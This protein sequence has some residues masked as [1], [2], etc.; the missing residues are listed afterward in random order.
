[1]DSAREA[2]Y[3]LFILH[4]D[5]DR[6]WVDGYL[7][8][9]IGVDTTRLVTRQGFTLGASIPAEF[10]RVVR[11]SRYTAVV[12]SPA[13]LADRWGEFGEQLVSFTSVEEDRNRIIVMTLHPCQT[14]LHVR[15]RVGLDCTDW[16]RWDEQASKIR[17]SSNGPI[18]PLRSS[19]ARI[20]GWFR[21]VLKMPPS[22]M[23][24]TRSSMTSCARSGTTRS[25]LWSVPRD[26]ASRQ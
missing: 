14:P 1:M 3:D 5:A 8:H 20:R 23:G 21:S 7:K 15:F 26:R 9:A 11:S 25:Y 2:C 17:R 4:A 22:F 16:T 10:D 6:A 12:L 13:F 19:P 18:H 24:A